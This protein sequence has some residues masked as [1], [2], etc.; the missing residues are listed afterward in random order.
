MLGPLI[1]HAL[2][3]PKKKPTWKKE[4]SV[5]AERK[6]GP[7]VAWWTEHFIEEVK[8]KVVLEE[9]KNLHMRNWKKT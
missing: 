5:M 7:L 8:R 1:L 2:A 3:V 9:R 4:M 6:I